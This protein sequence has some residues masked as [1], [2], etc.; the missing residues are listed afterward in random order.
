ML[1][2][3]YRFHGHGSLNYL[4]RKGKIVRNNILLLKYVPNQRRDTNRASVVVSKKVTKSAVVRNR[5]RRRV[6]EIIR[7]RWNDIAPQNDFIVTVFSTDV[8]FM[9]APDL[10]TAV[11]GLIKRAGL[12]QPDR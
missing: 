9:P 1:A 4:H 10:E 12:Y 7:R 8:A 5:I 3:E 2:R 11:V 6:Y